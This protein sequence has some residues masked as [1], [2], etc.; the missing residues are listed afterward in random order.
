M[1]VYGQIAEG[2]QIDDDAGPTAERLLTS[3]LILQDPFQP[4]GFVAVP[5]SEIETRLRETVQH[6]LEETARQLAE[7]P[8]LVEQLRTCRHARGG[9]G[10]AQWIEGKDAVNAAI[11]LAVQSSRHELLSAQPGPRPKRVIKLSTDRDRAAVE[12]G[13]AVRTIY[14]ASSRSNPAAVDRVNELTPL[15]AA[16]RTL[17]RA[18]MRLILIDREF[19]IIEDHADGRPSFE[20]AYLVR[21]RA[22]CGFL[23][24]AFEVEWQ[25]GLDWHSEEPAAQPRPAVTT[26]LQRTILRELCAGKDQQQIAKILGYSAKTVNSALSDLRTRLGVATVYQLVAWWAGPEG[27]AEQSVDQG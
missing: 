19:A 14:N 9:D 11:S 15:G 3:G 18:F 6:Q 27:V 10:I 26:P 16:F 22:V 2:G 20:G 7:I 23:A 5:F 4:S 17:P 25:L 12:R 24:A 13:V 8:V 1:R 21:D